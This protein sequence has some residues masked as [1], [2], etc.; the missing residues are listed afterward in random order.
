[1]ELCSN[2]LHII[3]YQVLTKQIP[4]DW[5]TTEQS[6]T[7]DYVNL[8]VRFFCCYYCFVAIVIV[9]VV[10]LSLSFFL[11]AFSF[12]MKSTRYRGAALT[13]IIIII[14][15][16]HIS[17]IYSALNWI[18]YT[19]DC[20]DDDDDNNIARAVHCCDYKLCVSSLCTNQ[21][22]NYDLWVVDFSTMSTF[23]PLPLLLP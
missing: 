14:I 8:P 15:I 21:N 1:M 16:I 4:P 9:V 17:K 22:Y 5:Y 12:W 19:N 3:K 11:L 18:R 7:F 13:R 2:L 10:I 6:K 23:S 20:D